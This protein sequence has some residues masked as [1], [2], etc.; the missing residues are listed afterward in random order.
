[1]RVSTAGIGPFVRF[2]HAGVNVG[3][4]LRGS[5]S[6][7]FE[8][9]EDD[10]VKRDALGPGFD[11]VAHATAFGLEDYVVLPAPGRTSVVY[12]LD[13]EPGVG[14][15]LVDRTLEV[16]DAQGTPRLRMAPPQVIDAHGRHH[17]VGVR[18]EDCPVDEHPAAPW[19]KAS[20]SSDARR[21][22]VALSW[23]AAL[24]HPA[25]LDP[26]WTTTTSMSVK[27]SSAAVAVLSTGK[28]LVSGGFDGALYLTV[29]E[30]FD[31]ATRTF[32]ATGALGTARSTTAYV[33]TTGPSTG[34]VLLAGGNSNGSGVVCLSTAELYDPV[35]G[36][37]SA[38]GAMGS[39]RCEFAVAP[40]AWTTPK[41]KPIVFGGQTSSIPGPPVVLSTAEVY[42][43][44]SGTFLPVGS[45]M[46][47]G[48]RGHA[49]AVLASGA[50]LLSGGAGGV[51]GL[52]T[53][54]LHT[55]AGAF[56]AVTGKLTAGRRG[57]GS[58]PLSSGKVL[59]VGGNNT[60][61]VAELFDPATSTFATTGNDIFARE[62][63]V[64]ALLPSGRVLVAGGSNSDAR[65]SVYDVAG[66][67]APTSAMGVARRA[68]T[69]LLAG[70]I[71][72]VFGGLGTGGTLSSVEVFAQLANGAVCGAPGDCTSGVCADGVCCDTACSGAC[73]ACTAAK[74]GSGADGACGNVKDASDPD[75]ECAPQVCAAGT[76]TNAFVCN[77]A[78][79]CRANG[80][81]TCSPYTCNT[82]GKA[83]LATCTGDSDCV[84][85]HYCD[86][87]SCVSK[88]A[89]G[90][91]CTGN[92]EC[93]SAQCWDSVCCDKACGGVCEA[94]S[95]ALKGSGANGKC[96]PVLANTDPKD[97]CTK[98]TAYP[99]SCKADGMCDG[100]GACRVYAIKGTACGATKCETGKVSGYTCDDGGNCKSGTEADCTPYVC[101]AT[102]C[103]P[104][105]AGDADCVST[106]Y[107][108]P[109]F[110]CNPKQANGAGCS[111]PK[112]CSSNFCVDGVCCESACVEQC[113]A[114]DVS[115]SVGKCVGNKGNPK[116]TRPACKGDV[117]VCGGTCD[118]VKLGECLYAPTTKECATKCESSI[119]VK[120]ICDGAGAC[121][122]GSPRPCG[123]YAC[124]G[125]KQCKTSCVTDDDCGTGHGCTAGKCVPKQST[126]TPDGTK[127]VSFDGKESACGFYRCDRA[128]GA[129]RTECV[130]SDDCALGFTCNTAT[131]TCV[132]SVPAVAD[133]GGCSFRGAGRRSVGVTSSALF[134]LALAI[135]LRLRR[136]S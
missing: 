131:K 24:Q 43:T 134:A 48:R 85:T 72:G 88:K 127:A 101:G 46:T 70:G 3:V 63:V 112:E 92:R 33:L 11:H 20:V 52:T 128:T 13:L 76:Q 103:K 135:A 69:G 66:T 2:E 93:S 64:A 56:S 8:R 126:C 42:N 59:I 86:G 54:E 55:A 136:A 118:G 113:A 116:G 51:T 60:N 124:D 31:P 4:S 107:C 35:A 27:R 105:C 89:N 71:V 96:E 125:T 82:M 23:E 44:D 32:A 117:A 104:S 122:V 97:K 7:A 30:L 41:G 108:T 94:C 99:T 65:A 83:C 130:A 5:A 53:A 95:A 1:M 38:T 28:V 106:A 9:V 16:V 14:L 15:R 6:R 29:N 98:D 50:V 79:A 78:G 61:S 84:S 34:R 75:L 129:C 121:S 25:I 49:V 81:V 90:V 109:V 77:G 114:C 40:A 18:V 87:G 22:S 80:T 120:S 12:D 26:A 57:H 115:G 36:T 45:T 74:K 21:C 123:A 111:S 110:T 10:V 39:V 133:E 100:A 47:E 102:A 132:Q 58:V 119:E 19:G 73:Q 17:P 67:F 91:G 68:Q 37:T 62:A